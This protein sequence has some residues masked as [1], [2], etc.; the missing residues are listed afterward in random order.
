MARMF[1]PR[2]YTAEQY[3]LPHNFS[4]SFGLGATSATKG[5][6]SVPI[7]RNSKNSAGV[8]GVTVNP[9]N[10][11]FIEETGAT[12]F[13]G[14]IVPRI[15]FTMSCFIP[16]AAIA[17]GVRHI[18][19]KFM[20]I[21]FSFLE[22]LTAQDHL[23][24]VSVEDVLEVVNSGS[25]DSVTPIYD[26]KL[27]SPG[28][29]PLN[30]VTETEVFGDWDLTTDVTYEG[31]AFN[32]ELMFD[33]LQFHTSKGMLRKAM[34]RIRTAQVRQDRPF[35]FSSNN[36][37]QPSVKRINPFTYCGMIIWVPQADTPGQSLL[38]SEITDIE[39]LHFN[40][41]CRFNEWNP[42]FDQTA[43]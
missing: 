5:A 21:Y 39:H 13:E 25:E 4:S 26:T 9:R 20:P 8:E 36:F 6:T 33:A 32:E 23:S 1:P 12:C 31:I 7:L 18:N 40:Y 29:M 10:A 43:I 19:F 42:N 34:G 35:H 11:A 16:E 14:S 22:S 38:D 30:T 37:T 3:P 27:F 24:N 41:R 15:N 28:N 17:T 2:G